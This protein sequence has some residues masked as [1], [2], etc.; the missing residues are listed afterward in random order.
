ME[1]I[2]DYYDPTNNVIRKINHMDFAIPPD[3]LTVIMKMNPELNLVE[4]HSVETYSMIDAYSFTAHEYFRVHLNIQIAKGNHPIGAMT[5][6]SDNITH[7]FRYTYNENKFISFQVHEMKQEPTV[8]NR[9]K[10]MELFG[11]AK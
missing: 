4:I 1:P 9:D 7:L 8:S 11:A 2:E 6:Y 5:H 10:F 3:F